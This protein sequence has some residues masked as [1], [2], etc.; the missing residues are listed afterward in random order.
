M[1]Y[2]EHMRL[3]IGLTAHFT[4][5]AVCSLVHAFIPDVFVRSSSVITERVARILKENG[6]RKN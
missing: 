3:A 1:T 5:A 4:Q 2:V 6:C